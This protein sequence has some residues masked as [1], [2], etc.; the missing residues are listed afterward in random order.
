MTFNQRLQR[1][2]GIRPGEGRTVGL[3]GL[4]N[5]LLGIGAILVYVSANLILLEHNPE[6]NLPLGYVLSAIALLAVAKG[7]DYLE[8]RLPLRTLAGRVL[9]VVI[10]LTVGVGGLVAFGHS[11]AAAVAIITGYRIIYLLASLEFWGVSAVV[12]DVRQSKRLFSLISAGDMPAK[13]LGAILAAVIHHTNQLY[14][15]LLVALAAYV[16]AYFVLQLTLRTHAVHTHA[17]PGRAQ[18]ER[19]SHLIEQ[20]FGGSRLVFAL[21]LSVAAIAAVAAGIE[22]FF[23][24]NVKEKF[25]HEGEVMQAVGFVLAG[26]YLAALLVKLLLTG[27][28]L[29]RLGLRRTL[30]L[31]PATVLVAL[32]GFGLLRLS[33]GSS[34]GQLIYFCGLFIVLEVLRRTVFE[35]AFLVLFQPLAP[36]VRLKGHTLAKGF[37]EP[38]GMALAGG[39]LLALHGNT[40]FGG[41]LPY[42]WM[43]LFLVGALVL[44]RRTY[45]HYLTELQGTIGRRFG[46]T[47]TAEAA[48]ALAG[49]VAPL[50]FGP[51]TAGAPD[52]AAPAADL[53]PTALLAALADRQQHRPALAALLQRGPAAAPVLAAALP[54]ALATAHA[55]LLRRVAQAAAHL[56]GPA[57][58][59]LLLQLVQSANLVARAAG[60]KAWANLPPQPSDTP[61]LQ[62]VVQRELHLARQLLHGQASASPALAAAL[63]YELT[64][65]QQRLFGLLMRLHPAQVI[66]DA[67]RHVAQ[68]A[69][70]RQANALEMLDNLIPRVVYQGLQTLLEAAPAAE[71]AQAF[72]QLLGPP[73]APLPPVAD[74]IV[75]QGETVFSDWTLALALA[76]WQPAGANQRSALANG[77]AATHLHPHLQTTNQLVRESAAAALRTLATTQ[78]AVHQHLLRALPEAAAFSAMSHHSAAA[79]RVSAT[80]RVSILKHTALFAETPE[81]VLSAIVPIMNEVVYAPDQRIFAKGDTGSSLF[82][83]YE[84]A[85]GIYNGPQLLTTFGKGDFFG[86]LALLDAEPRSASAQ[87]TCEVLAFRLDQDDFYDVM[88]ER[89]EVLRNILRVLC[90]RL[91]RQNEKMQAA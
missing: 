53:T 51:A 66:A 74:F 35:P 22:F 70:E 37:Y 79:A 36:V 72:D 49:E 52:P 81:N 61:A 15:L 9:L 28:G 19:E 82:I 47:E 43:A 87:A 54:A 25:H 6:H 62:A 29:D 11:V 16:G 57:G 24:I 69:R 44:L 68:A 23:F 45:A 73:P 12:F 20:L 41:W 71:K 33:G 59:A 42:A 80:E 50:G 38:V 67:Q 76:E 91:R 2:L 56:P 64:G 85:V 18:R 90:Q 5:F 34:T 31:L 83:V 4:H 8:H 10:G 60:L 55:P 58:P 40:A 75:A 27:R 88:E 89:P 14:T 3:F 78:P 32:A 86:E 48:D 7:Y 84:G 77:P 63:A 46:G 1:L 13:A 39:L 30:T 17:G 65:I 26:T 21:C